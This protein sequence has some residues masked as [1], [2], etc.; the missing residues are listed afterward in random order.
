[1]DRVLEGL[2]PDTTELEELLETAFHAAAAGAAV[3]EKR[4]ESEFDAVN[5]TSAGDWVTAFDVAAENAVV[6]VLRAERPWD[7]ITGE[8]SGTHVPENRSPVR[9]S[10]DP[11]DGT[12]NFIRDI[13]YYATSVAACDDQGNWLVG[14]VHAPALGRIYYAVRGMGAW[15]RRDGK[16]SRLT[17]PVPDRTGA[18]YGTGFSY[19]PVIR[20]EQF[21]N[22]LDTMDHYTDMRRLGAAS[23]DLCMVAD[24]TLDGYSERGLHEHDWAAGALI[25]EEAGAHVQR[26]DLPAPTALRGSDQDEHGYAEHYERVRSTTIIGASARAT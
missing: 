11:L 20:R 8:E 22:F 12:T 2:G 3:L 15:V 6:D 4:D 25:A 13:V 19:D 10:V 26:P 14:V 23:L 21:G 17:G 16:D 9:W 1:M 18:L 7:A 5:K 24:G